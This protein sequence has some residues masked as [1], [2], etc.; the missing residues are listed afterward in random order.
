MSFMVKAKR[1]KEARGFGKPLTHKKINEQEFIR[2]SLESPELFKLWSYMAGFAE[3]ANSVTTKEAINFWNQYWLIAI[4]I[5]GQVDLAD[6][7]HFLWFRRLKGVTLLALTHLGESF[8]SSSSLAFYQAAQTP[9][10]LMGETTLEIGLAF[11]SKNV[12]YKGKSITVYKGTDDF[13][14]KGELMIAVKH[15]SGCWSHY[16]YSDN[17]SVPLSEYKKAKLE[18][19]RFPIPLKGELIHPQSGKLAKLL[20][21]TVK[22]D[23][24]YLIK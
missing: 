17:A 13:I 20:G 5:L 1:R 4:T 15:S 23:Y 21:L 6:S 18:L 9:F 3:V 24:A 16:P 11:A 7:K 19:E 10:T 8:N 12:I 2:A 14:G 22:E